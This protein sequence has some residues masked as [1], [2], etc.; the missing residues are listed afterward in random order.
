MQFCVFPQK[1][2]HGVSGT[3][4]WMCRSIALTTTIK[5]Q[6]M[7]ILIG[8]ANVLHEALLSYFHVLCKY[9]GEFN[10]GSS[11]RKLKNLLEPRHFTHLNLV[12]GSHIQDQLLGE[13]RFL[14]SHWLMR[15]IITVVPYFFNCYLLA[16]CRYIYFIYPKCNIYH[17]SFY[18]ERSR[19][20]QW[21]IFQWYEWCC[22]KCMWYSGGGGGGVTPFTYWVNPYVK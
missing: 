20:S 13:N 9:K 18:W 22:V 12:H 10:G 7:F 17:F 6:F 16:V 15:Y 19:W 3:G 8:C 1:K 2:W 14:F 4:W 11:A 21:S 5:V